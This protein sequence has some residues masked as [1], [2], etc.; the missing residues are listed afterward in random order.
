MAGPPPKKTSMG[1]GLHRPAEYV[2]FYR[3]GHSLREATALKQEGN[4]LHTMGNYEEA[5]SMWM[6]AKRLLEGDKGKEA[7]TL[8]NSCSLNMASCYILLKQWDKVINVCSEIL[9]TAPDNFKALYRRALGLK[10]V[11]EANQQSSKEEVSGMLDMAYRDVSKARKQQPLDPEVN[12]TY[13]EL[14]EMMMSHGLEVEAE[15]VTELNSSTRI[16]ARPDPSTF[17]GVPVNGLPRGASSSNSMELERAQKD[18]DAVRRA[19]KAVSSLS[20]DV[21]ATLIKS[22]SAD[23]KQ[24]S[25]GM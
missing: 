18:P 17:W 19:A 25:P 24:P 20:P 6:A 13:K 5:I 9:I 11:V 22:R 8:T 14:R 2:F 4:Q 23:G 12:K 10:A 3:Q 7:T 15:E 1:C 16:S 21:L